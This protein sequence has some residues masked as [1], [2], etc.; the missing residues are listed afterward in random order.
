MQFDQLKRRD[1]ITLIGGAA[2][3]WPLAARAQRPAMPVIGYLDITNERPH[4]LASFR[5]GLGE[6]GYLEGQNVTIDYR[7]AEGQFNRLP[8][9]V[10]DFVRLRVSLIAAPRSIAAALAAKKATSTIPIVFGVGDDPVKLGL[11]T[12]L[13]RPGGNA[14]GV[15][16]FSNELV[17]KRLE[18]LRELVPTAARIALLINP[19]NASAESTKKSAEAA[20]HSIGQQLHVFNA[21]TNSEIDAAFAAIRDAR[22]DALFIAP[23]PFFNGRRVQI[24]NLAARYAIP[25]TGSVREYAGAGCLMSYG[26]NVPEM[27]RQVGIYAGQILRGDKPADLPVVQA[28]KFELVINLATAKMLGLTVPPTLLALADEVIE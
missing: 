15:N 1:F 14:T 17:A 5:Q 18:L 25:T 13:A 24:A 28:G 26:T 11:V 20:A 2:A 7:W 4:I 21:T 23:D 10:A 19:T 6:V 9:L 8:S 12:S 27:S 22:A 16:F 3:A